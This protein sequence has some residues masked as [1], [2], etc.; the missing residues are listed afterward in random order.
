MIRSPI[1]YRTE[2]GYV[3]VTA[4]VMLLLLTVLGI[5]AT[6]TSI[7]E[8][9]IASNERV[10]NQTFYHADSGTHL[11]ERLVF[12]NV[13]CATTMDGFSTAKDE[14]GKDVVYIGKTLKMV[15]GNFAEKNPSD[16]VVSDTNYSIQYFP[17][18]DRNLALSHTNI[19]SEFETRQT[20]GTGQLQLSGYEGLAAGSA[21]GTHRVYTIQS[22]HQGRLGSN[23]LVITR[24]RLDGF[25]LLSAAKSDCKY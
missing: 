12:E 1:S 15:D 18:G 2:Q 13:V 11:G 14:D 17:D 25:L 24:W 7:F 21:A 19:L 23:S 4:L 10:Y 5:W 3:L 22:Q 8:L 9:Q 6:K 20:A 16:K